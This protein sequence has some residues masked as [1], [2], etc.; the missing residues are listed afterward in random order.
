MASAKVFLD[1]LPIVVPAIGILLVLTAT[2]LHFYN[3]RS[4]TVSRGWVAIL[5]A[6]T[7]LIFFSSLSEFSLAGL[8]TIKTKVQE[9]KKDSD[10][11]KALRDS[12]KS[13]VDAL[14]RIIQSNKAELD[15][16]LNGVR[17]NAEAATGKAFA[18][19]SLI[20]TQLMAMNGAIEEA[21]RTT[22]NAQAQL[23]SFEVEAAKKLAQINEQL[24][25]TQVALNAVAGKR[26]DFEALE[27]I[28]NSDSRF[29]NVARQV[30]SQLHL[31]FAGREPWRS[32][33][34]K[35]DD[36]DKIPLVP[37]QSLWLRLNSTE[38]DKFLRAVYLRSDWGLDVKATFL[39]WAIQREQE[40]VI[41][42]KAGKTCHKL[43]PD[44]EK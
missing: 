15:S 5:F 2:G 39:N 33:L 10:E 29:S 40:L 16:A 4:Q 13:D 28:A 35:K 26:A 1:W 36:L 24:D 6:G 32:Y 21:R 23:R 19:I 31:T 42:A 12:A 43:F 14:A 9:A 8:A 18:K 30:S 22:S 37:A 7:A 34:L 11:I 41:I 44:T 25:F 20:D 17:S 3:K 38:R 27:K